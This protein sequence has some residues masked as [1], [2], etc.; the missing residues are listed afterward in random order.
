M[1]PALSNLKDL[2]QMPY[3]CGE[4]NM[5]SFS[6]NIFALQYLTNTNQ[7]LP[8]IEEEAKGY[9]RIGMLQYVTHLVLSH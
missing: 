6:P 2:L 8:K 1:G 3:G 4:Q 7:L 5:A 9:M